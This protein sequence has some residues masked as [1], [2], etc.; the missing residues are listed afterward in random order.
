MTTP[1]KPARLLT[2]LLAAMAMMLAA[3]GANDSPP[4]ANP[5]A[6][7]MEPPTAAP[8]V[9]AVVATQ[10]TSPWGMVRLPDG[11]VLV[12]DRDNA[13]ISRIAPD[14]TVTNVGAVADV[15]AGGEGGL[16]G[17]AV[18]R[19]AQPKNVFV[20][21]TAANDNRIA[22]LSWNGSELG[23]QETILDGIPKEAIHNGGR[24]GFGP[25]DYLYAGTGDAGN[26]DLAQDKAS[27][28]GKILRIDTEGEVPADNPF[29]GSPVWSLGHRNVQGLA[30]AP[31]GR[32]W[33]AEFGQ[34]DVDELN[35]I[36][37]GQNYG[38]PICEGDCSEPGMTNPK[39]E[40]SPTATASPSGMT[41]AAGSAWV[42][43]LRGEVLYE[44]PLD[45]AKAATPKP[46]FTRE[47]GRLRDVITGPDG[48]LW[49]MTNN[50]DGR[51]APGPDD[52]QILA[53]AP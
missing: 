7:S 8:T 40:W 21:F 53:V 31:D 12:T 27:L 10:L 13:T 26:S 50:T 35:L 49:V 18:P 9:A 42:A 34:D 52:D 37:P 36:E 43:S 28:G 23:G 30:W 16:L 45:G 11:S 48:N 46:W 14:R 4:K 29:P 5:E 44:V 47:Y 20:Y 1:R 24:I 19:G 15:E 38:W 51:G 17:I 25:D 32:L 2:P 41:I 6:A 22:R 39:V 33:S 3:C